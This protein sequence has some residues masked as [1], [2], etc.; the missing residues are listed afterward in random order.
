MRWRAAG[1]TLASAAALAVSG[2]G[3]DDG[4]KTVTSTV[5]TAAS[6]PTTTTGT[7]TSPTTTTD[8]TATT[9]TTGTDGRVDLDAAS[10]AVPSGWEHSPA[11]LRKALA[12]STP[13]GGLKPVAMLVAK[14]SGGSPA[15]GLIV[16]MTL[17]AP[18]AAAQADSDW[19]RFKRTV[20]S[21]IRSG[22]LRNLRIG[23]DTEVDGRRALVVDL[24]QRARTYL[25][26][27][28]IVTV[29]GDTAYYLQVTIPAGDDLDAPRQAL[30]E[31]R[32]SWQ[33]K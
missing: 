12:K 8:T 11:A 30:D 28:Q 29:K 19:T 32:G 14:G 16:V 18:G 15:K 1:L 17:N 2:C 10:F 22:E 24:Q 4:G 3:G 9:A 25:E 5:T 31:L 27:R 6:T 7:T 23:R 33:W 20:I 21:S 13:G 26:N